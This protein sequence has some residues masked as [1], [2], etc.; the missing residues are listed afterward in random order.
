MK[1][2]LRYALYLLCFTAAVACSSG[3]EDDEGSKAPDSSGTPDQLD[4]PALSI[5]DSWEL[6][7]RSLDSNKYLP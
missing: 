1:K 4:M 6:T 3:S 7:A 5:A 2:I